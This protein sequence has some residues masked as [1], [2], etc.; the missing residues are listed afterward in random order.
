LLLKDPLKSEKKLD[1][2]SALQLNYENIKNNGE[3]E[4]E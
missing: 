4:M 2:E 3:I 1:T